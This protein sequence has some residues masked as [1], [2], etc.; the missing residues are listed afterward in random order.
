MLEP[1]WIEYRDL[2]AQE[3][4]QALAYLRCIEWGAGRHLAALLEKDDSPPNT[5]QARACILCAK[6]AN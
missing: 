4:A 3:R 2:P 6:T 1:N 5:A